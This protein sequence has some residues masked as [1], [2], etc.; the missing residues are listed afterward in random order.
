MRPRNGVSL[1]EV[2]VVIAILAI[3]I[4]L[5][6]P[7][8]QQVREA[9]VRMKSLN[10]QKQ[11]ALA[12]H[13]YADV[14]TGGLPSI[15]GRPHRVY[16]SSGNFWGTVVEDNVFSGIL[17]Y[18]GTTS[19]SREP[20]YYPHVV[21]YIS[22][23]DPSLEPFRQPAEL[24]NEI[25]QWRPISYVANAFVFADRGAIPTTFADGMSNTII[26]A[27]KYYGCGRTKSY[28]E[29]R[30]AS[31]LLRRPTFADGGPILNGANQ[32][33]VYPVT[34][35]ASGV[36]RP[37]RPGVTFQ[38][39]PVLRVGG[40][41]PPYA[42]PP[43][44]CDPALP[45][46]PHRGGMLVALADGSCRTVSPRINPETFWGAVTPSGGEVLGDW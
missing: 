32:G 5:L 34:D 4:G 33:D 40:P 26:I 11:I 42:P 37:S 6:L 31:P 35:P 18:L 8:V 43:G 39:Q 12:L 23:A 14:N 22:P 10:N 7:A 25:T 28:Y 16:F 15:D 1:V 38:V 30:D 17:P 19:P 41:M 29:E 45:G 27:E 20:A 3:L 24:L 21:T 44:E 36:T 2:L 46:T 13:G 9:A